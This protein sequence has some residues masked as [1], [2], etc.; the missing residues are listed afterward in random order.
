MTTARILDL[1]TLRD[2]ID[3]GRPLLLLDVLP[4]TVHDE[5]RIPGS[6]NA[7]IYEVAFAEQ[8]DGL[9]ADPANPVVV[10]ESGPEFHAGEDACARLTDLGFQD[11]HW[12]HGG[13]EA[14]SKAGLDAEGTASG[15]PWRSGELSPAA[16]G[17]YNLDVE[18][19]AVFWHGRNAANGHT[20]R[21]SFREGWVE[22]ENG[23]PIAGHAVVDM[24]S[25]VCEDLEGEMAQGLLRHLATGDFFQTD[26]FPTATFTLDVARAR[27][28][29]AA[30]KPNFDVE[31]RMEVRG[32]THPVE[33]QAAFA[34]SGAEELA[35]QGGFDWDRTL[36]GSRYGSGRLYDRLGMHIVN[37]DV[38]IQVRIVG[39]R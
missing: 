33:F 4:A 16:P 10:Y 9:G 5:W 18:K 39:R 7:C 32:V 35:L 6:K 2:W 31:G 1:A 3:Q 21:I 38:A 19:S 25:I 11:V 28:N 15:R 34:A 8:I 22:V 17:H 12:F 26:R 20:G 14:W 29:G 30:G 27:D 13:R 37:D 24:H 23:L 36:W